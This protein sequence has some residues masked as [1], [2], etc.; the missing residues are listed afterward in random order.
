MTIREDGVLII[1]EIG[2]SHQGSAEQAC[3]LIDAAAEAGADAVKTQIVFADEIIHPATGSVPLPGGE[4]PLYDIFKNLEREADF[5]QEMKNHA[6]KRGIAFTASPFGMKSAR[7]LK[8]LDPP[9]I[10]IA[11]PEVN[12]LPLLTE[13]SRYGVPVILSTGVSQMA[14]VERAVN[15][16]GKDTILLH[17]VTAYPAPEVDYNLKVLGN[18]AGKFGLRVGVSD[19]SEDPVLV[20]LLSM[21]CGGTVIEKHLTLSRGGSGLD[22]PIALD[23]A[24]FTRMAGT[25]RRFEDSGRLEIM[26]W[27]DGKYGKTLVREV[28]GDGMKRLAPSEITSYG[29]TNRSIHALTALS[30]GTVLTEENTA[31]LR[32]E[33]KLRPGLGPEYY[34]IVLGETLLKDVPS[35]E[36]IRWED[37]RE[38]R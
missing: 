11:S 27:L 21:S 16:L 15:I 31:L 25:V 36:G 22:D 14:E 30:A 34:S 35:G 9:F 38:K 10:K 8:D 28:L 2:T 32:T 4:T 5:Y 33:K 3:R 20:P 17:C 26:E 18:Y 1:A 24:A 19:H 29:R 23:P 37:I 12:H 7:I 6:D 13:V